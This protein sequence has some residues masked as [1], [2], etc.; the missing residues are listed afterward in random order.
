MFILGATWPIASF[1]QKLPVCSSTDQGGGKRRGSAGMSGS[2]T[3]ATAAGAYY[4]QSR[5]I[6][7]SCPSLV[8]LALPCGDRLVATLY[9]APLRSDHVDGSHH[10]SGDGAGARRR[11]LQARPQHRPVR[12]LKRDKE[13]GSQDGE[14]RGFLPTK[15]ALGHSPQGFSR[16][17]IEVA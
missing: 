5:D 4:R 7:G 2:A 13:S 14:L 16:T 9:T 3:L 11:H 12:T 10:H 6:C 15:R 8:R 1:I 17:S